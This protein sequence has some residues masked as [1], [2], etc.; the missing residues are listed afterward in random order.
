MNSLIVSWIFNTIDANLIPTISRND[1][2][3]FGPPS[4]SIF[5]AGNGPCIHEIN[6]AIS[7][8][9]QGAIVLAYFGKLTKL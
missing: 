4:N 3:V 5:F 6:V 1:D 7:N 8:C 2:K 9:K